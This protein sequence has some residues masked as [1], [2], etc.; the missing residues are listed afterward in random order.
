MTNMTIHEQDR[1]DYEA[2]TAALLIIITRF[3][4]IHVCTKLPLKVEIYEYGK[5]FKR[6]A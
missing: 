5:S 4:V 2:L 3:S 6:L 1:Q